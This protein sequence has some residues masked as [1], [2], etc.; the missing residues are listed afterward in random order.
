MRE[1]EGQPIPEAKEYGTPELTDLERERI[2]RFRQAVKKARKNYHGLAEVMHDDIAAHRWDSVLVDDVSGRY[3]APFMRQL[4]HRIGEA[5]GEDK[6]PPF[7]FF[8]GGHGVERRMKNI[9]EYFWKHSSEIGSRTLLLTEH[10][11]SGTSLAQVEQLLRGMGKEADIA[12]LNRVQGKAR[13]KLG[14]V[15]LYE[16]SVESNPPKM[17]AVTGAGVEKNFFD[18]EAATTQKDV[19]ESQAMINATR[20]ILH[21]LADEVYDEISAPQDAQKTA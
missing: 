21:D 8:A 7:R 1:T 13:T 3:I 14:N 19:L 18:P 4:M 17:Y 12:T 16:G 15:R 5:Q 11:S 2:E 10:V 6:L 20:E 9:E